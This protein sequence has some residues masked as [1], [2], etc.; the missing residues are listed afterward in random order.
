MQTSLIRNQSLLMSDNVPPAEKGYR[1]QVDLA[2]LHSFGSWCYSHVS[3]KALMPPNNVLCF[4]LG[5]HNKNS[6][7][8]RLLNKSTGRIFYSRAVIF[9]EERLYKHFH[10]SP[11]KTNFELPVEDSQR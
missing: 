10:P 2:T 6:Q 9:D 4:F 7:Y 5:Y 1:Q 8:Y 11:T 3:R